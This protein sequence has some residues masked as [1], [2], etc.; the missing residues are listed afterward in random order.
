MG[1]NEFDFTASDGKKIHGYRWTPANEPVA[2]IQI[3]HGMAEHAQR[4]QGFASFLNKNGFAVYAID[5]RGHGKTA[6]SLE[7]RGYF[8]DHE[9]WMRVTADIH[10]INQTIKKDFPSRVI[11]M[12][13]HS[14][15]SFISRTFIALHGNEIKGCILSGTA[16]HP[17]ALLTMAGLIS[18][19]QITFMG[20]RHS[21]QLLDKLSFGAFNKRISN[22]R[23]KFDWVSRDNDIVDRYISDPFCGFAGTTAFF[24]DLFTGLKFIN[25]KNNIRKTPSGLPMLFISGSDDPVGNYGSGVSKAADLYK[26]AGV[27]DIKVNIY[28][29]GRHEMLNE[30]NK[31]TVYQDILDWLKTHL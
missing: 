17:S 21:S 15:G 16:T 28:D 3:V 1:F 14:M 8:A 10:E 24:Y 2:I 27:N 20:R 31:E 13:G 25:N 4:Y 9:G 6:G 23:T 18:S 26:K 29:G 12:L 7:E 19:L 30:T 5:L 22:P 11:F